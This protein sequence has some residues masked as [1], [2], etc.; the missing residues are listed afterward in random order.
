MNPQIFK[1]RAAIAAKQNK[2]IK[3]NKP[4]SLV[5]PKTLNTYMGSKGY[6][7]PKSEL[8]EEQIQFIKDALTVSPVTPGIVLAAT[9]KFPA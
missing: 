7:I 4:V 6:T 2:Q 3:K 5:M 1:M 8:S 9:T